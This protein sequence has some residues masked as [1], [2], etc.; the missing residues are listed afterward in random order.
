[1]PRR[2]IDCAACNTVFTRDCP[3]VAIERFVA[4]HLHHDLVGEGSVDSDFGLFQQAATVD[5]AFPLRENLQMP[6]RDD[7]YVLPGQ[8]FFDNFGLEQGHGYLADNDALWID[9]EIVLDEEGL[10]A[11]Q[12]AELIASYITIH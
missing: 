7:L 9:D 2:Q 6:G 11:A 12:C 4:E 10:H 3:C 8:R 1:M 5:A